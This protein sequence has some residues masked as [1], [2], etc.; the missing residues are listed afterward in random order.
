MVSCKKCKWFIRSKE[1]NP[2]CLACEY[3][4]HGITQI[5]KLEEY[6]VESDKKCVDFVEIFVEITT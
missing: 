6:I 5:E 4:Q 3:I 1:N 2:Y